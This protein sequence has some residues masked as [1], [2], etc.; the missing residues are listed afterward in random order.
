MIRLQESD[1]RYPAQAIDFDQAIR[2]D[3]LFASGQ[4][5]PDLPIYDTYVMEM[6]CLMILS[7]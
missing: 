4:E 7:A 6:T 1:I 5:Q 3:G 2:N